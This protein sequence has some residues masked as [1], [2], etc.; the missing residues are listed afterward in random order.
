MSETSETGN[1]MDGQGAPHGDRPNFADILTVVAERVRQRA[2]RRS[3]TLPMLATLGANALA[4]ELRMRAEDH[5]AIAAAA[6]V[7]YV[8]Q[9]RKIADALPKA[10]SEGVAFLVRADAMFADALEKA[11]EAANAGNADRNEETNEAK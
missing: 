2:T 9:L 7:Q 6:G 10:A 4:I 1:T 5:E 8:S 3:N 11:A